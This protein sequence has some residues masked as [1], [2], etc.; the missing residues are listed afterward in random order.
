MHSGRDNQ[1]IVNKTL[2]SPSAVIHMGLT[3]MS[4]WCVRVWA[5]CTVTN[6]MR[7]VHLYLTHMTSRGLCRTHTQ[8]RLLH[9]RSHMI[10]PF[11]IIWKITTFFGLEMCYRIKISHT[12]NWHSIAHYSQAEKHIC[13][14][15]SATVESVCIFFGIKNDFSLHSMKIVQLSSFIEIYPCSSLLCMCVCVRVC[16]RRPM[17]SIRKKTL[18]RRREPVVDTPYLSVRLTF[19]F[20]I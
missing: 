18:V 16:L 8:Q 12:K 20:I 15:K 13:F 19:S 14:Q 4:Q 5:K 17:R 3:A 10:S 2:F 9:R 6:W 1:N 11:S 7:R